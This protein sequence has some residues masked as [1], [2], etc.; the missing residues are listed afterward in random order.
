MKSLSK[1]V[2]EAVSVNE[3]FISKTAEKIITA[4]NSRKSDSWSIWKKYTWDK[5]PDDAFEEM[6]PASAK[7]LAYKQS[8]NYAHIFWMKDGQTIA[9]SWGSVC[10]EGFNNYGVYR[11][12][13]GW[14]RTFRSVKKI[15]ETADTA[16]LL[17]DG[18]K[19]ETKTLRMERIK[20]KEGA[21][22]L[23]DASTV[24]D[25]N[26]ARYEKEIARMKFEKNADFAT[27]MAKVKKITDEYTSAIT[28]L[29]NA[30]DGLTKERA[31]SMQ[32]INSVYKEI[33]YFVNRL[34]DIQDRKNGDTSW[35]TASY[36]TYASE[37][38]KSLEDVINKMRAVITR[39]LA[40]F[41]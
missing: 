15:A 41:A 14:Q 38:A 23:M 2:M 39:E 32:N 29:L 12:R 31:D 25:L 3:S 33:L 40:R 5:I 17:K 19:Y 11:T 10:F 27:M 34:M 18:D 28:E 35:M 4:T 9:W 1:F 13:N 30:G 16:Y 26:I 24:R 22:A 7:K 6:D 20:A 36:F 37:D 21:T 8:S